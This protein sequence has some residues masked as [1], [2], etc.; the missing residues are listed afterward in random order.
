ML[1]LSGNQLTSLPGEIGGITALYRL[2]LSNNLLRT[3]PVEIG[4]ITSLGSL[5]L[6]NNLLRTLPVEMGNLASL[7]ELM[8]I[9]NDQLREMPREIG[10]RW[11]IEN[12]PLNRCPKFILDWINEEETPFARFL[13]V[14]TTGNKYQYTITG[15]A[16]HEKTIAHITRQRLK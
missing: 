3:L 8:L 11:G 1:D 16:S 15:V 10:L 6:S 2:N 13:T 9:G 5:D 12:V 7:R 14:R 4:K